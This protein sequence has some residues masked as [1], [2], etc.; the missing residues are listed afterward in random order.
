MKTKQFQAATPSVSRTSPP[1]TESKRTNGKLVVGVLSLPF[2]E[3]KA[4]SG[5]K[6]FARVLRLGL[7]S[8]SRLVLLVVLGR[9]SLGGL[10]SG[11][12]LGGFGGGGLLLGRNVDDRG[13]DQGGLSP[14]DGRERCLVNDRVEVSGEVRVGGTESVV[15]N[16]GRGGERVESSLAGLVWFGARARGRGVTHEFHSSAEHAGDE[17][18]GKGD[19]V[20]DEEGLVGEVLLEDTSALVDLGLGVL[21]LN[22]VVRHSVGQ[23]SEPSSKSGEEVDVGPCRGEKGTRVSFFSLRLSW[24][25]EES[26]D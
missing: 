3:G 22:L 10:G 2:V 13:L 20:P 4:L 19:T 12:F 8:H 16:L 24:G 21:N 14:E 6:K 25:G 26:K 7:V 23:G 15:E 11:R 9:L 18:V 1:A 17:D 5:A